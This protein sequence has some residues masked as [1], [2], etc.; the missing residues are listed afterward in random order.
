MTKA[1]H[2]PEQLRRF[3]SLLALALMVIALAL[4]TPTFLTVDNG[5][6]VPA[7]DLR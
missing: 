1:P 4:T 3:Q 5:F 6:N 2:L 7:A